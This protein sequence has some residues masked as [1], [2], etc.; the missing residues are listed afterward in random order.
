M[1]VAD[2]DKKNV[3][4]SGKYYVTSVLIRYKFCLL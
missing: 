2:V 3:F 4:V 1:N